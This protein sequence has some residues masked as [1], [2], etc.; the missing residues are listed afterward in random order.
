MERS[1]LLLSRRTFFVFA[2][3]VACRAQELPKYTTAPFDNSVSYRQSVCDRQERFNSRN[4]TLRDALQ[5]FELHPWLPVGQFSPLDPETSAIIE[6]RPGF[7][8]EILD[9]VA[10][11]AGFSWRTSFGVADVT[12]MGNRTL[13]DV[14]QWTAQTYDISVAQWTRTVK[15]IESGIVFPEGVYDASIIMVGIQETDSKLNIWAFL[16]PFEWGV[17][18]MIVVRKKEVKVQACAPSW[19]SLTTPYLK[20]SI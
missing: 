20:I 5:G 9:E 10:K 3:I 2:I 16:E 13:D 19:H 7:T 12:K 1:S 8:V 18:V 4:V 14:L 6:D 17:W 15:R 11:R